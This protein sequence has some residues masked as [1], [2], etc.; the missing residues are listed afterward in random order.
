[1]LAVEFPP[2]NEVIRWQ[3]LFPSFNKVS[4]ICV[5]ATLIGVGVS[6]AS[7]PDAVDPEIGSVNLQQSIVAAC[8]SCGG[9]GASWSSS[10]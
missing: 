4:L 6:G 3:D 1:M 8:Q 7:K 10:G 2:I 5:L 9:P